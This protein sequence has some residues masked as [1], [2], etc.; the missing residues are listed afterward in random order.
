MT[1][2]NNMIDFGLSSDEVYKVMQPKIEYFQLSPDL[3]ETI[4]SVLNVNNETEEKK[5]INSIN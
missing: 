1:L 3:I 2:C 4:K 5:N